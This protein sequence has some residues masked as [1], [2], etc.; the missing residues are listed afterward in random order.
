MRKIVDKKM[1]ISARWERYKKN[2]ED[3]SGDK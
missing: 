1:G 2:D 3:K